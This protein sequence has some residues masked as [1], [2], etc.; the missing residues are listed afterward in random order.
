M[1]GARILKLAALRISER[2]QAPTS[3]AN[4]PPRPRNGER[5][6]KGPTPM[7]WLERAAVQ[8]GKTL[9][10]AVVLWFRAGIRRSATVELCSADVRRMGMSRQAQY[11]AL[12]S[13]ESAALVRV[14]RRQGRPTLVTLLDAPSG[15]GG[16]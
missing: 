15:G 4:P 13:L 3:A 14:E 6:L 7:E 8:P 9:E 1:S 2:P 16:R 5:F 12:G 11:R 10:V